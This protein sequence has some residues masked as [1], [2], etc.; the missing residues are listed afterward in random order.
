M[1]LT[2]KM[3]ARATGHAG[4]WA[5]LDAILVVVLL[6]PGCHT[7][8]NPPPSWAPD[9]SLPAQGAEPAALAPC[10][11]PPSPV[12]NGTEAKNAGAGVAPPVEGPSLIESSTET[13]PPINV[14]DP[15]SWSVEESVP[16][17]ESDLPPGGSLAGTVWQDASDEWTV[18]ARVPPCPEQQ[19]NVEIVTNYRHRFSNGW[20]GGGALSVGSVG[21]GPFANLAGLTAEALASVEVNQGKFGAWLLRSG[22]VLCHEQLE[23]VSRVEYIWHPADW[24]RVTLDLDLPL[25]GDPVPNYSLKLSGSLF[26]R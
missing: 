10:P 25:T 2:T 15:P 19:S 4:D 22:F 23:P 5:R 11:A 6:L 24:L 12:E 3:S 20:I 14:D 8:K 26:E 7:V 18:R 17:G 21:E 13:A 9:A 1:S 16:P